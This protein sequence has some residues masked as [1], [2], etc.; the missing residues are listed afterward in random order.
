VEGRILELERL[1][2]RVR[3]IAD[4][5]AS[6]RVRFGSNVTL[7]DR[8]TAEEPRTYRIVESVEANPRRGLVSDQSPTGRAL[9]GH[10]VND[11]VTIEAPAGEVHVR[12]T[13]IC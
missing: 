12:I 1:L 11:E 5:Q 13:A 7:I 2:A 9:L 10:R 6:G 8:D 4:G 3:R